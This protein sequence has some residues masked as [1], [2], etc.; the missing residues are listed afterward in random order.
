MISTQTTIAQSV[1]EKLK[2][3]T[4]KYEQSNSEFMMI[5]AEKFFL[6]EDFTR[7]LAFLDKALE[8]D[9]NNH[10]AHFKKAEIYLN[11]NQPKKGLESIKEA[12]NLVRDNK[13]YYVLG[14]QLEKADRNLKGTEQFYQ[15]MVE[16][17]T[18]FQAYLIE[19]ANT[20]QATG[21]TK[22]AIGVFEGQ[23]SLSLDQSMKLV[24]MYMQ[25]SRKKNAK[26]LMEKL[27]VE[28]P[29]DL[30]L[31]YQYANVLT[32]IGEEKNAISFLEK[33]PNKTAEMNLMLADLYAGTGQ[34]S[35]K[36]DL[37][38]E[39]FNNPEATLSEKTLLLGQLLL[40][41]KA[42]IPVQLADSLQSILELQ[43][44]NE[45]LAIEN[46]TYVYSKLAEITT[47]EQQ[48]L[49]K[50]KAINRYKQLKD[51]KP[52]EFKVWDKVL[53]YENEAG[54]WQALSADAEEALDLYPNQAIFYIYLASAKIK[55]DEADEANDLLN[56]AMRMTRTN[57]L[58]QSQI[59]GKQAEIALLKND[60]PTAGK[61]YQQAI[62]LEA[63]HP[64]TALAYGI[65]T[66]NYEVPPKLENSTSVSDSFTKGRKD[67]NDILALAKSLYKNN[68][69]NRA[70]I[71]LL[72]NLPTF[73]NSRNGEALELYGDLFYQLKM[74]KA[75]IKYWRK[76][77][78]FGGTSDKID[79][80][81]ASGKIN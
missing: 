58:L 7:A 75:A 46:G 64:E 21:N 73:E 65:F 49:Y 40:Q 43:Y 55:L 47:E 60:I 79:Q 16:N 76:A 23:K 10:A 74:G 70:F 30:D 1:E 52:G 78:E 53:S 3:E 13:Y 38:I 9:K 35:A 12:I 62:E 68:D 80:K 17:T 29:S 19:L 81:I 24:E 61:L 8:I 5:E 20:F 71:L 59:L 72:H 6:L 56:Q 34:S 39:S 33:L 77:K 4:T 57:P 14:A 18:D 25:E 66:E 2:D 42:D 27:L 15:L 37:L 41:A 69:Y 32:S 48:S 50:L 45:A 31:K 26:E 28:N 44:P 22:K 51:L 67:L 11:Q 63:V 54:D 36:Y